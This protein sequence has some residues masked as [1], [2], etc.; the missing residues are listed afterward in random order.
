MAAAAR[1]PVA[2]REGSAAMTFDYDLRRK[3]PGAITN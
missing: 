3:A 2:A 1:A